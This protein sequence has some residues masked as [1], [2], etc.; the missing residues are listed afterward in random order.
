MEDTVEPSYLPGINSLFIMCI[1][2][3]RNNS[4][5]GGRARAK[6]NPG[7][8]ARHALLHMAAECANH[9]ATRAGHNAWSLIS[10]VLEQLL[11]WTIIPTCYD[12]RILTKFYLSLLGRNS[13][14]H[15]HV[16]HVVWFKNAAG[17]LL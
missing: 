2:I 3:I 5:V 4:L 14:T 10:F 13:I 12:L 6:S 15:F 11:K 17:N 8:W 16:I 9:S 7:H 1:G